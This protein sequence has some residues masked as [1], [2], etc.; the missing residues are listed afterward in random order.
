LSTYNIDLA[1]VE[2]KELARLADEDLKKPTPENL[3]DCIVNKD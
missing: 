3:F 2:G 1:Y